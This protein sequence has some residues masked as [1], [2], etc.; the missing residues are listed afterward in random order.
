MTTNIEYAHLVL[1]ED[2]LALAELIS[3]FFCLQGYRVTHFDN[4]NDAVEQIPEILPECV[5]LD[6]MLPGIDGIEVCRRVREQY[7][8][9]IIFLTAKGE[10]LD[11]ILGLEVGGDDYLTK[12]VEPRRLLAHVR[13]HLRRQQHYAKAGDLIPPKKLT[14][15]TVRECAIYSDT[16]I[17]LSQA[18]FA[19]MHLIMSRA[20]KIISR[21]EIMLETRGVMHDGVSR[22][23]DILVSELRKKL[24]NPEWIKTVRGK[25]YSWQG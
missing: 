14:L 6:I 19:F 20:G 23:V 25:G 24:P 13:A 9:P 15:D 22:A 2:D 1:V 17:H 4:G 18:E 11:E 8:G 5:V 16:T 12:P 3:E 10:Q 7:H 21:D